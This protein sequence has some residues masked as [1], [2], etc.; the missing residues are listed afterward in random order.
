M[1]LLTAGPEVV[2]VHWNVD[3]DTLIAVA[4]VATVNANQTLRVSVKVEL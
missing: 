2:F 3:A 1:F 4:A